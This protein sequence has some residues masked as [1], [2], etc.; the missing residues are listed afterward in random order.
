MA[1]NKMSKAEA[2]IRLEYSLLPLEHM[3]D[4]FKQKL[5]NAAAKSQKVIEL[6]N[7]FIVLPNGE[8]YIDEAKA[9]AYRPFHLLMHRLVVCGKKHFKPKI[10]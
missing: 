4:E 9:R 5:K 2:E 7:G 10:L 3:S 1:T 6:S 8:T